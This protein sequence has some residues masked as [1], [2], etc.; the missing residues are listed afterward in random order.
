M[1]CT[2]Q[3]NCQVWEHEDITLNGSRNIHVQIIEE[4]VN[5]PIVSLNYLDKTKSEH[6]WNVCNSNEV[7][8]C[9]EPELCF[10]I[11]SHN[12]QSRSFKISF[13]PSREPL[14]SVYTCTVQVA[15]AWNLL[16]VGNSSKWHLVWFVN[17]NVLCSAKSLKDHSHIIHL[18]LICLSF[19]TSILFIFL[20]PPPSI[21]LFFYGVSSRFC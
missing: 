16:D 20:T 9:I 14:V 5:K 18:S 10:N 11:T 17:L 4:V 8:D 21:P 15:A 7:L 6:P 1:I 12:F 19:H 2:H 13:L 3:S